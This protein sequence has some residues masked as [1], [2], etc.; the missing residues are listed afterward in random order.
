MWRSTKPI[1]I[2][3]NA[4][5]IF[6]PDGSFYAIMAYQSRGTV[7]F[8]EGDTQIIIYKGKYRFNNGNLEITEMLFDTYLWRGV[9]P[10]KIEHFANSYT[11]VTDILQ[12][13]SK[14][15]VLELIDPDNP[16]YSFK[17]KPGWS[18]FQ[19]NEVFTPTF[20]II[21]AT[22]LDIGWYTSLNQKAVRLVVDVSL[23]KVE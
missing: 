8:P 23:Q 9:S 11:A 16:L 22:H 3:G 15:D 7:S 17:E 13:G 10:G 6:N 2:K 5:H 1:E 14:N 18:S 20:D 4:V 12:T 21:N 19:Y